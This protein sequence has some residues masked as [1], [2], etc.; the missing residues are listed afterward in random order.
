MAE[1][2]PSIDDHYN[3]EPTPNYKNKKS[4]HLFKELFEFQQTVSD[5]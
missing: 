3:Y 5:N 2:Q 4:V 1:Q